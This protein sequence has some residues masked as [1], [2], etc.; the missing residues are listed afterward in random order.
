MEFIIGGIVG[1]TQN[2]IGHPFDTLKVLVQSGKKLTKA[3]FHPKNLYAGMSY[4]AIQM[5]LTNSIIFD[6]YKKIQSNYGMSNFNAAFLSGLISSPITYLFECGK[7]RRQTEKFV[8]PVVIINKLN[9]TK[10]NNYIRNGF[11]MTMARESVG[12]A[13]YFSTFYYMKDTLH[14]SSFLSGAMA[15]VMSW[16]TTYQLDVLKSRQMSLNISLW[17]AFRMGNLWKGYGFCITRAIIVNGVS[18]WAYDILSS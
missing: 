14:K 8:M 12:M 9:N 13:F 15:G 1:L 16:T 2:I 5:I 11:L 10:V 18:L 17:E 7:I 4:P 6:S 3:N